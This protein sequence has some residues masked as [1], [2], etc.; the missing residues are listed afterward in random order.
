MQVRHV[1]VEDDVQHDDVDE[2]RQRRQDRR[3]DWK[4]F[5]VSYKC[6]LSKVI[7]SPF[8]ERLT[9]LL[10]LT[11]FKFEEKENRLVMLKTLAKYAV[12]S[13]SC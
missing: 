12:G 8:L 5:S 6:W 9:I 11:L 13:Q 3:A 2:H 4:H 1:G 7:Q 10:S